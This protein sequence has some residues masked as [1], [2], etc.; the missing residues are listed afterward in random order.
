MRD[1]KV[2]H[3]RRQMFIKSNQILRIKLWNETR[4]LCQKYTDLEVM[5]GKINIWNDFEKSRP[6][7]KYRKNNIWQ[8]F[9]Q[10]AAQAAQSSYLQGLPVGY[11]NFGATYPQGYIGYVN[12][13]FTIQEKSLVLEV[14]MLMMK[15]LLLL[16]R[17]C[18][19]GHK[20][21]NW[22]LTFA[23]MTGPFKGFLYLAQI[24]TFFYEAIAM[25]RALSQQLISRVFWSVFDLVENL[26][27]ILRL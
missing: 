23:W 24:G 7:R 22:S 11:P 26:K 18:L 19:W 15:I 13:G 20:G 21:C 17:W 14:M 9:F 25:Q 1:S 2:E 5:D 12:F 4:G 10:A 6:S 27:V 3:F 16:R 8:I